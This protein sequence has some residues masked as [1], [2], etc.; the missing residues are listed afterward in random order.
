MDKKIRAEAN[1][2]AVASLVFGIIS[3]LLSWTVVLNI[4][5]VCLTFAFSLLSRGNKRKCGMAVTG[6]V[7]GIVSLVIG[8]AAFVSLAGLALGYI[9]DLQLDF[10]FLLDEGRMFLQQLGIGGVF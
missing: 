9:R 2:L 1:G 7:L 8:L 3:V 4:P 5:C 10:E 6:T